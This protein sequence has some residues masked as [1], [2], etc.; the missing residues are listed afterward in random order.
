MTFG[1]VILSI[2]G[3]GL[4][5]A[6]LLRRLGIVRGHRDRV[7]YEV[8][9]GRLQAARAA[10]KAI[11]HMAHVHFSSPDVLESLRREYRSRVERDGAAL[12]DL[13]LATQELEAEE[14]QWARRHLLLVERKE[15]ID[16]FHHG[17]L[18]QGV[19]ERLLGDIDAELLRLE[20][21]AP[22]GPGNPPP[23]SE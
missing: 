1:V 11:D 9:R 4:T 17:V 12:A 21:E 13:H 23:V 20:S 14:L 16:A 22:A 10:L 19:E 15:V 2:L 3:N 8:T 5:V 18:S 6:P 7:A